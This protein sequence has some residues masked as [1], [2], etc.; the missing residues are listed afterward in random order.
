MAF[1]GAVEH[2]VERIIQLIEH[3]RPEPGEGQKHEPAN[4]VQ[5]A[6]A[7]EFLRQAFSDEWAETL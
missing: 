1:P 3:Q 4:R 7:L 5:F 2:D 6:D